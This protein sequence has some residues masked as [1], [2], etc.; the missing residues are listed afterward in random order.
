MANYK[1]IEVEGIGEAYAA[2]LNAA[3]INNTDQL[4]E[5]TRTKAMRA[6]LAEKSG[7]E[8][9]R[10]LKFANMVDLFR[11]KGVGSEYAELLEVAGV[12]TVVELA[13]RRADNLT[14]KM[15]EVNAEKN[16]VRSLPSQTMVEGWIAQAKELPRML[17]Y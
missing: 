17:E 11:I 16:L 5:A 1:V 10:I 6:A 15:A 13:T 3:G 2:K 4:L 12:D 8:E 14:A 9:K 7:I